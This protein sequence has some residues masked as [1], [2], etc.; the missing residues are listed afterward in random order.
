MEEVKIDKLVHGG[1]GL[2]RLSDGRAVF[3]WNSLPGELVQIRLT[4][5]KKDYVEGVAEEIIEKSAKRVG[6]RDSS[7]MSTSPWQILDIDSENNYKKEIIKETFEREKV[8]FSDLTFDESKIEWNYRN[9]MEYSFW[10]DDDGL[11]LALFNR[12][13][14]SKITL[15]GSSIARPEIDEVANK[16]VGIL[17]ANKIRGT[18]LKSCILRCDNSGNVVAGLFVK[19]ENFPEIDFSTFGLKGIEVCFS[20]PKSPASVKTKVLYTHGDIELVDELLGKKL[21]YNVYSFFQVNL[22]IF[23]RVLEDIK[24]EVNGASVI[25]FYSGVG[26]HWSAP[27]QCKGSG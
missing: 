14:H 25:D 19:D 9:K 3:A 10:A 6:P 16:I 21:I 26:S 11:S 13:T 1:Q 27:G 4:K 20:N 2:G 12:G 7:F 22:S 24:E 17:N 5:K 18:Q 15:T 23:S 8:E